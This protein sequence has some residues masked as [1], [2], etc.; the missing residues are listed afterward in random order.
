[1][2]PSWRKSDK[3]S[4]FLLFSPKGMNFASLLPLHKDKGVWVGV[5]LMTFCHWWYTLDSTKDTSPSLRP[6]GSEVRMVRTRGSARDCFEN[7]LVLDEL[8]ISVDFVLALCLD[9]VFQLREVNDLPPVSLIALLPVFVWFPS[10][11]TVCTDMIN[12]LYV[13]R[14]RLFLFFLRL[15]T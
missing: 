11:V 9:S 3:D 4:G 5:E 14:L 7:R 13:P 8:F 10:S 12:F 6:D 1:M 2:F 15:D